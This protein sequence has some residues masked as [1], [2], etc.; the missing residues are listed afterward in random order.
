[1]KN[2]ILKFKLLR[3]I[4]IVTILKCFV[5]RETRKRQLYPIG[6]IKKFF[7]QIGFNCALG[8]AILAIIIIALIG[9]FKK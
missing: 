9:R 2:L 3:P 8:L 5:I 4:W 6:V 7:K 1:M